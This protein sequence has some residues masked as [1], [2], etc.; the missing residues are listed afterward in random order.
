[1]SCQLTLTF[2]NYKEFCKYINVIEKCKKKKEKKKLNTTNK[3]IEDNI[4]D[5]FKSEVAD[6]SGLHKQR[7]HN[8]AKIYQSEH[9]ELSYRDTLQYVYKGRVPLDLACLHTL[10]SFF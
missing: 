3:T 2:D 9:Q 6:K 5:A 1:M 7:Y 8:L 4:I 10:G